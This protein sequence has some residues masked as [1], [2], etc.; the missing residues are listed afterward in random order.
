MR[1]DLP[2]AG[3]GHPPRA[4]PAPAVPPLVAGEPRGGRKR[5]PTNPA[6]TG[7]AESMRSM[8]SMRSYILVYYQ[9]LRVLACLLGFSFLVSPPRG[10]DGPPRKGVFTRCTARCWLRPT[11]IP[12]LSLPPSPLPTFR[13]SQRG[14]R[15]RIS[16]SSQS[17]CI[18]MAHASRRRVRTTASSSGR[19]RQC[20][21]SRPRKTRRCRGC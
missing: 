20:S 13:R 8:R 14:S 12:A 16:R 10:R 5:Q 19:S 15:M 2:H 9:Y 3:R 18:Q 6:L 17:T 21:T 1:I 4:G 7:F 11:L